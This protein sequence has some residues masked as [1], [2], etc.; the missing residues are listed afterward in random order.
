MSWK[1]SCICDIVS[2]ELYPIFFNKNFYLFQE[3]K[4][5]IKIIIV[6]SASRW[7]DDNDIKKIK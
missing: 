1:N 7:E 5:I 4:I 3:N 6:M 2:K